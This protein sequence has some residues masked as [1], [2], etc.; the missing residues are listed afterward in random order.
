MKFEILPEEELMKVHE[1]SVEILKNTGIRTTSPKFRSLLLDN[2]CKEK[3]DRITF[4]DDVIEKALKSVPGPWE[5]TSRNGEHV[6]ELCRNRAYG[7]V[8]V[9]MPAVIDLET[10]QRRDALLKDLQ[11]FTRLAD[12][13]E[14]INVVSPLY[15]RDVSQKAI[16]TIEAATL[17]RNTTK[18]IRLCL[19]S[20]DEWPY[21]HDVLLAVAG[22]EEALREKGLGY[23]EVSPIS[24][25]DFGTGPAEALM[26]VVEAGLPLGIDPAPIMGATSPITILGNVAQ[27]NAEIL[28]AVIACQLMSPGHRVVM[29]PRAGGIMDMR[30][31]V[32][33]WA[34]PEMGIGGALA[35]QLARHYG[36]ARGAGCFTG[37]SKAADAQSGYERIYN[38]LLP[39]LIGIDFCGTA[40]SVDNALV[41]SY[42]MLVIDNE[43]SSIIQHTVK[44][45]EVNEDKLAVAIVDEVVEKGISF[46]EHKHTRKH[47][48]AGELWR[49]VISQRLTFEE[50]EAR[51]C[52]R[53]EDIAREKAKELLASHRVEPLSP[54]VDAE[55]D[56]IIA[57]AER[58]LG[59]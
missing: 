28:A 9:G 48:R 5:I 22:S 14:F 40:G 29:S 45:L 6:L 17:L 23:Y 35:V 33:L 13:L 57:R 1:A 19:E 42:E 26:D 11:D 52:P 49:P 44:G 56:K 18:P 36:I 50:W 39:A 4:T 58:E 46:L 53:L 2:G 43:M 32:A 12:A 16:V 3:K 31:G 41:G 21:I 25:L 8:C 38:A 54:E 10:G 20:H 47:L 37:A 24:P 59:E 34:I 55:L 51:G 30:T 15:P 7:Q 27:H